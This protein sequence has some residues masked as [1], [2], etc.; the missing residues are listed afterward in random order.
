MSHLECLALTC[1][2]PLCWDLPCSFL[3]LSPS[4]RLLPQLETSRLP[5]P[6]E[7]FMPLE[8]GVTSRP[9]RPAPH[10]HPV[11]LAFSSSPL[12]A[13]TAVLPRTL[14]NQLCLCCPFSDALLLYLHLALGVGEGP[15]LLRPQTKPSPGSCW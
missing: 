9:P 3:T 14:R 8:L 5:L 11:S 15:L 1:P 6:H 10:P 7:S 2:L 4:P 13:T 12:Y